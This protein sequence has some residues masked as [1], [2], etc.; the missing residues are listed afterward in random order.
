MLNKVSFFNNIFNSLTSNLNTFNENEQKFIVSF[1]IFKQIP[2][3]KTLKIRLFIFENK[4]FKINR[5]EKYRATNYL[6]R[7]R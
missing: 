5:H 1:V 4:I 6:H 3:P 2:V 7:R